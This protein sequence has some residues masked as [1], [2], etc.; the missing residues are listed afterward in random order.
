MDISD[1]ATRIEEAA[2]T[3]ALANAAVA[4]RRSALKPI[5]LCLNC[6]DKVG[7][8]VLF[9]HPTCTEDYEHWQAAQKRTGRTGD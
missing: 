3:A 9:C 6:D 4:A 8:G 5:G 7:E 2:R 1:E